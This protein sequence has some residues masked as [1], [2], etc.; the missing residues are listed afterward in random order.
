M[1]QTDSNR[2]AFEKWATLDGFSVIQDG[3]GNY[4]CK[5][6][7]DCWEAYQAAT[8][9]NKEKLREVRDA[10]VDAIEYIEYCNR[11]WNGEQAKHPQIIR[12]D[13]MQAIATLNE[14]IGGKS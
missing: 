7:N 10:I 13:G 8:A 4:E 14:M 5:S 11:A 9:H 6:C 1:T 3:Q 12:E 2:E